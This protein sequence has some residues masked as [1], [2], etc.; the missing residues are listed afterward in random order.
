[1]ALLALIGGAIGVTV[2]SGGN[3]RSVKLSDE[4]KL[5][6]SV[7]WR[8]S[9]LAHAERMVCLETKGD[10]ITSANEY[11]WQVVDSVEV[12]QFGKPC[13]QGSAHTHIFGNARFSRVDSLSISRGIHCVLY[14]STHALCSWNGRES[15][16]GF[17]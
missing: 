14:S 3:T 2:T 7:L 17:R 16:V 11:P 13:S 4:A 9:S 10:S 1:M 8:K 5:D 6:F 15:K 12:T